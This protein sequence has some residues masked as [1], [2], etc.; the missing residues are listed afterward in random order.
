MS[1][2]GVSEVG[3]LKRHDVL[4][5]LLHHLY[6]W[7]SLVPGSDPF[8]TSDQA[9][10]L[11]VGAPACH[12]GAA[13]SLALAVAAAALCTASAAAGAGARA[14]ATPP[15]GATAAVHRGTQSLGAAVAAGAA[16]R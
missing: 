6:F 2:K 3:R 12:P 1:Q 9:H 15:T 7:L 16:V 5:T 14:T 13:S 4:F 11:A 8:L 10:P